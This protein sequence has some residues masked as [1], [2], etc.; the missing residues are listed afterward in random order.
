MEKIETVKFGYPNTHTLVEYVYPELTAV[1]PTTKLPD[2]YTVRILFEPEEKLPEL[3]SLKL[4]FVSYRNVG[5]LHENLANKI[6]E[7]FVSVVEPKWAFIELHVNNRGG[8]Y[9]TIRRYWSREGESIGKILELSRIE[10]KKSMQENRYY[11]E[12]RS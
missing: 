5:I 9:T 8:I 12:E 1:C 11:L 4:Y 3:K 2:F 6:L 7:D 10:M